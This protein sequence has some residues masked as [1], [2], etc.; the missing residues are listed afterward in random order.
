MYKLLLGIFLLA[1]T[2]FSTN[3]FAEETVWLKDINSAFELAGKE[4]KT[5][6][7]LVEGKNC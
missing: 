7:V 3:L 4:Q 5:V 6:V 2:L 1:G